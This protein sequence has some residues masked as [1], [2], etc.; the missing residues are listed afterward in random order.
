M[1]TRELSASPPRGREGLGGV[2]MPHGWEGAPGPHG[3]HILTYGPEHGVKGAHV[4][5]VR[6]EVHPGD[7]ELLVWEL[8]HPL[9][10]AAPQD[11][12]AMAG[13]VLGDQRS[14]LLQRVERVR[15]EGPVLGAGSAPGPHEGPARVGRPGQGWASRPTP[16]TLLSAELRTKPAELLA[17]PA[18]TSLRAQALGLGYVT[19]RHFLDV[20]EPSLL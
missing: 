6:G 14:H 2:Q 1:V 3:T 5:P 10:D 15:G 11:P 17:P 8:F 20:N 18:P 4:L 19:S 7:A 12:G 13:H 9:G 16:G